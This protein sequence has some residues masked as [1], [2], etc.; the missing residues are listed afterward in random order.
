MQSIDFYKLLHN[1]LKNKLA[2]SIYI[3]ISKDCKI[4]RK[5]TSWIFLDLVI[6]IILNLI[7]LTS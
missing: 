7:K 4:K 1:K 5:I 3:Y 6:L 2:K